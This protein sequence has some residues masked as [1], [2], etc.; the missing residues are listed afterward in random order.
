MASF[1][2][3]EKG[4]ENKFAHDQELEFKAQARR[5]RL[6][7]QW[8]AGEMG[9]SGDDADAYAASLVKTDLEE[10]GDADVMRKI[11]ADFDAKGVHHS[12]HVIRLKMD[13]LLDEAR[14][15]IHSQ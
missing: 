12:D 11:R 7:G 9:L 13:Q 1:E 2:D 4:F 5:N 14:A 8:A 10:P 15:Q 3:R 6:L